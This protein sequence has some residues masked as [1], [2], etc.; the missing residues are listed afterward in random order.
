MSDDSAEKTE[1]AT[2]KKLEDARK[3]GQVPRSREL[4]TALV[5]LVAAV[6][7]F[8][9][10]PQMGRDFANLLTVSLSPAVL[11]SQDP[12]QLPGFFYSL[13]VDGLLLMWPLMAM[14]FA[15]A[16]VSSVALGGWTFKLNLKLETLNPITGIGKVFSAKSLVELGK[17]LLK[18]VFIGAAAYGLLSYMTPSILEL[19]RHNAEQAMRQSGGMLLWFFLIVSLPLIVIALIDVPWQIFSFNKQLKMSRQEVLDEHK[20]ANGKPEVKAKIRE[21]Q[22]AAARQRMM[23]EVPKAD[24]IITNPTHFAVALRYRE[25]GGGAPIVV[26][27]GADEVAARIRALGKANKVPLVASPRLARALFASTDLDQEIPSGLY[28]AVAQI[29]TYVYQLRQWEDLGGDYPDAP[30]PVVDDS[31]L[32]GFNDEPQRD[33][34]DPHA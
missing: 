20:E 14:C 26:A 33:I 21:L 1:E 25:S 31:Y 5:T 32:T 29:L 10:G 28:L 24:V 23:Q 30:S 19:S 15:A 3:K 27:K 4:S 8:A 2:P 7:L 16:L 17:S 22:Q 12:A 9:W 34:S 11:A 18:V 6:T 13:L